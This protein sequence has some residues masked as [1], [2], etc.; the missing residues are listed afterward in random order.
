MRIIPSTEERP[1]DFRARF[2]RRSRPLSARWCGPF[3][4]RGPRGQR[5][6]VLAAAIAVP[7]FATP[8]SWDLPTYAD[9][10]EA[11]TATLGFETPGESFPG[12]AFYYLADDGIMPAATA[13]APAFQTGAH[14]DS[15]EPAPAIA[16]TARPLFA[17]GSPTDE[18]RALH[19]LTQA[20]YYEAASESDAG[21]RAVAQVVLNRVSHPAYPN[22][23]CGVVYQGSERRTGCQFTFTC[24]G[25]LARTPSRF[26]WDRA[27]A[28][29]Q[30]A[31]AG[32]VYAPV[33]LATHYH[34]IQVH[35]YWAPSL[36]RLTT[37]GAHIFYS[38]R[39]NA[40]RPAAF[41][42]RYIG[43]EPV[44]APHARTV[45]DPKAAL[46]PLEL[47]RTYEASLPRGASGMSL[48]ITESGIAPQPRPDYTPAVAARGG[49][50]LYEGSQLPQSGSV[51]AEFARSGEW[52]NKP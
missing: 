41:S 21:Q 11:A 37:I 47:A 9:S 8:A 18:A 35:P 30:A 43:N 6:A 33:G 13:G 25:S 50:T 19:C 17:A 49:D 14:W 45:S 36:N 4:L 31:L 32:A 12:S 22:T 38:W 51:K 20:I 28:A 27:H 10:A 2:R 24:D 40:G 23:V 44:A 29:A 3:G 46:D 1:G 5:L 39:G 48:P 52:I 26:A 15:E 7:A 16:N 34:T 42:D